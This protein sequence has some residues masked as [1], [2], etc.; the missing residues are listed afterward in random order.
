MVITRKKNERVRLR[1][2]D[3][4]DI[5]VTLIE[6]DRSKVRLGF[7]AAESVIIA[8]EE[9]LSASEQFH[10]G[11]PTSTQRRGDNDGRQET[12]QTQ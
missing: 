1:L 8:R 10:A 5:W 11:T 6:I 9:L 4:T 12:C 7:T 2:P 3:G